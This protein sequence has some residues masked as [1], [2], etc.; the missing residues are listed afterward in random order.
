MQVQHY[1]DEKGK[2]ERVS[3]VVVMG[4]GEL[5]DNYDNV[6][7]FLHIINN[8]KRLAIGARHMTVSTSGL[9]PK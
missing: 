3:H 1:L 5:F 8:A 7:N 4:I 6:M 9:A 2:G